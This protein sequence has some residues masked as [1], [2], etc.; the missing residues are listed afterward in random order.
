M[1]RI[2]SGADE[3]R[4]EKQE[5]SETW[6][7]HGPAE[8]RTARIKIADYS[9]AKAKERLAKAR[10]RANRSVQEKALA[11]QEVHKTVQAIS[12]FGSQVTGK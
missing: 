9:L 6:Y 11:R 12:I 3:E 1:S 2:L 7:H 5:D 4:T 8:L 10:L